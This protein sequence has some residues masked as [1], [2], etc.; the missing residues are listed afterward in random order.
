VVFIQLWRFDKR[1]LRCELRIVIVDCFVGRP[2]VVAIVVD[3]TDFALIIEAYA[4]EMVP[5]FA[6]FAADPFCLFVLRLAIRSGFLALHADFIWNLTDHGNITTK[7]EWAAKH[8]LCTDLLILANSIEAITFHAESRAIKVEAFRL[9]FD[10]VNC[11]NSSRFE[12]IP[13]KL[14]AT[15][16]EELSSYGA[17]ASSLIIKDVTHT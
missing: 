1:V 11:P 5:V 14:A 3:V 2:A 10:F 6:L 9:P 12:G 4:D 7:L 8:F 13:A 17:T 16:I 15:L